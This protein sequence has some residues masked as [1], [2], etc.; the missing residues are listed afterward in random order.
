MSSSSIN[1]NSGIPILLYHSVDNKVSSGFEKWSVR[2]STFNDHM[3]FL[4]AEGYVT[5]T[6]TQLVEAMN[7]DT[8]AWP[9]HLVILTFDDGFADFHA[10]ALSIL[11][12]YS[13]TATLYI[14][15]GYVGDT[16]RWLHREGEGQ[17]PMLTW[18][19]IAEIHAAG[20]ECAAHTACHSHLDTLPLT[21]AK[22]EIEKSKQALEEQLG[23]PVLSFAYPYG[24]YTEAV[25]D[26]V[27]RAG[28][29]SAC[30]VKEGMSSLQDDHLA[31]ARVTVV[32]DM[33]VHQLGAVV[34]GE[35]L[36]VAPFPKQFR[37]RV[38]YLA[39]RIMTLAGLGTE[40]EDC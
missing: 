36:Q 12:K 10:N 19:Q 21:A 18:E 39:R 30:A 1:T 35:G 15:T 40:P 23:Q 26:L 29:T 2:P 33:D 4:H 9:E 7:N 28:F 27:G 8:S 14:T 11:A 31:L 22:V 32:R 13:Y 20:I 37:T 38:G 16:S 25:R 34:R 3:A 17:R 6:V 5:W 24:H